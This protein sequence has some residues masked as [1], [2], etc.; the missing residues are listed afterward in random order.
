MTAPVWR[1]SVCE[2]VNQG[3]RECA[4]CGAVMT[5]ASAAATAVRARVLPGPVLP[6]P[7]QPLPPPVERAISR[8]PIVAEEWPYDDEMSY[9]MIPM[10]GGCVVIGS[11]RGRG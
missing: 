3:T 1:C 8:E 10:P 4:A 6:S 5:R 7:K 2:T 11:P 9:R